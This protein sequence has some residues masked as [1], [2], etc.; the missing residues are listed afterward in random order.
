MTKNPFYNALVAA[1]YIVLI[2][3][4]MNLMFNTETNEGIGQFF[5][6]IMVISLFT[7]SAAVM[8]YVFCYQPLQMYLDGKKEESVKL[9]LKTVAV[10]AGI[11]L[12][13]VILYFTLII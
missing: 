4:G 7:L 13:L 9:F 5:I 11:I 3:L 8:G 12:L 6:P 2:V 1:V 10:F